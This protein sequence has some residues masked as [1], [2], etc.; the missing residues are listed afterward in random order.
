MYMY[1]ARTIEVSQVQFG[2]KKLYGR[3]N[4][5]MFFRITAIQ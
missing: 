5:I 3:A 1:L 2:F 4:Y